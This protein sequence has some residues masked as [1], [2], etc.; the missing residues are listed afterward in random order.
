MKS[1]AT[2]LLLSALAAPAW[3]QMLRVPTTDGDA[4]ELHFDPAFIQRNKVAS[5][6][7]KVWVK[8]ERE[9]MRERKE[10]H[11]YRF[12]PDG[13][14]VY[15]NNSFGNPGSGKD[16]AFT[17]YEYDANGKLI[18]RF[19]GDLNGQYALDLEVDSLGRPVHET[20]ARVENLSTDRYQL[21]PGARTEISDERFQYDQINHTTLGKTFFNNLGLKYREQYHVEDRLGYK[22]YIEDVYVISRRRSRITFRHDEQGRVAER[23]DQNDLDR[24]QRTRRTYKYDPAGN[25]IESDLWQN[26]VNTHHEEFLYEEST[27]FLKARLTKDIAANVIHVVQF[28]TTRR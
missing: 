2:F 10:K 26:E 3:G 5:A 23:I 15:S 20:Y 25:L 1:V 8:R 28:E 13:N 19:R 27:M 14:L 16:T 6:V 9:P 12:D 11:L 4:G 18:R 22:L 17:K 21:I 7:G 24:E